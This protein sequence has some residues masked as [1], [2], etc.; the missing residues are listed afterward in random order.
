MLF[1]FFFQAEDGIR[2]LYVTGVQT[3]ALPILR[4][5]RTELDG[6][7]ILSRVRPGAP[8]L[9]LLL[10]V[11]GLGLQWVLARSPELVERVF[12][13]G[14]YPLLGG[15][16]GCFTR[17]LPISLGEC[18]VLV[19]A[20]WLAVAFWRLARA[21]ERRPRLRRLRRAEEHTS[22]LQSRRDL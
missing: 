2:D 19:L 4:P 16:M 14:L 15:R 9:G 12:A 13:R 17:L 20:G 8:I 11:G 22:E 21:R 5:T 7:E 6:L 18:I 10:V 3:C 1:F